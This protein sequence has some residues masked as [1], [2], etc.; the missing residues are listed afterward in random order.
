MEQYSHGDQTLDVNMIYTGNNGYSF[1]HKG[2][3]I[4]YLTLVTIHEFLNVIRKENLGY[5][6]LNSARGKLS[7]FVT[8]EGYAAGKHPLV[9]WYIK[10][11]CNSNPSSTK[12]MIHL[13]CRSGSQIFKFYISKIFA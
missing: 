9:C 8:I 11:V 1:V 3:V 5:S 7:S 2:C 13:G 12:T 10:D 6:L 4:R